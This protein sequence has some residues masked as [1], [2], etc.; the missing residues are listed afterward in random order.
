MDNCLNC[1]N[2]IKAK[3]NKLYEIK[4]KKGSFQIEKRFLCDCNLTVKFNLNEKLDSYVE[5]KQLK[6]KCCAKWKEY[7]PPQQLS[8]FD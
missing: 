2:Y 4:S 1:E 7:V 6:E 3:N 8:I 5:E